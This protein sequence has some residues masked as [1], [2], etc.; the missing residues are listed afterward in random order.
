MKAKVIEYLQ[1]GEKRAF[2]SYKLNVGYTD[3]TTDCLTISKAVYIAL[4]K[5]YQLGV[6][7]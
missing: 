1:L 5:K 2:G 3:M 7:G 6:E 4:L